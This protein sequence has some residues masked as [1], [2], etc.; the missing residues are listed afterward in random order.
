MPQKQPTAWVG[1]IYFASAM[2]LLAG[3]LQAIVGLVAIFKKEFYAVTPNALLAFNVT[4]WGWVHLALGAVVFAAGLGVLT[5]KLWARVVG[6][7]LAVLS[8]VANLAFINA[9]PVWSV[10]ALIVDVLVIFA[11]TMHGS[12]LKES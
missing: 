4:T 12:E 10:I 3:S 2:M 8:A 7:S 6:V 11:L 5:G 1:W 9:Y